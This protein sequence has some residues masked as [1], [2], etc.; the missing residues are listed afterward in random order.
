VWVFSVHDLIFLRLLSYTSLLRLWHIHFGGTNH[1]SQI[2]VNLCYSKYYCQFFSS[3]ALKFCSWTKM[4][5]SDNLSSF[6]FSNRLF[7]KD[8]LIIII[9]II[10]HIFSLQCIRSPICQWKSFH[11]FAF[12]IPSYS[13]YCLLMFI[14]NHK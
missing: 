3:L 5:Y 8:E 4:K 9:I 2:Y 12:I 1:R 6:T 14:F 13:Q 7:C 11:K 10:V